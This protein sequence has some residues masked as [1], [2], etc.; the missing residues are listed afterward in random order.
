MAE[1]F[2]RKLERF[3]LLPH[4]PHHESALSDRFHETKAVGC[5]I[6]DLDKKQNQGEIHGACPSFIHFGDFHCRGGGNRASQIARVTG[7][8]FMPPWLPETD[9]V[10]FA[11]V[12]RLTD[13][14]IATIQAW[15]DQGTV[16]GD[17]S[18]LPPAP[19]WTEGW[20]L[21]ETDLVL[22]MHMLPS[23]KPEQIRSSL[24]LHFSSTP[25]RDIPSTLRLGLKI[26][27]I[28]PGDN[29][30]IVRDAYVLP[31][32]VKLLKVY[33]RAHLLC[34]E[35]KG[36]AELPDGSLRRLL[37][38]REWD[39]DWQGEYRYAAPITLL[40]GTTLHMEYTYD[41]SADN[42]RNPNNPP[43]R[44]VYSESTNGEM[45]DLGFQVIPVNAHER[46]VLESHAGIREINL[47]MDA[48]DRAPGSSRAHR[49]LGMILAQRG[50]FKTAEKH[51]RRSLEADST[52]SSDGQAAA[53]FAIGS[54]VLQG[55]KLE[56]AVGHLKEALALRP[57]H[58]KAQA[59]LRLTLAAT[60][61]T[62]AGLRHFRLALQQG[63]E[64][65]SHLNDMAWSLSTR[66]IVDARRP[67]AVVEF[68]EA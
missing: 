9:E 13:K 6:Q 20:Q 16:E 68:A 42:V 66:S 48:V 8:R 56:E 7:S 57:D 17:P 32:D 2:G 51:F 62:D 39:F 1:T 47:Y 45:G 43:Q 28:Q 63:Y 26:F 52:S 14:Q 58:A 55:G 44:V 21:G 36:W 50:D 19:E 4:H 60:G 59:T 5:D 53:H 27:D 3:V 31:I 65:P 54:I 10:Q 34:R 41:N 33:P 12:R 22:D 25:P 49:N 40:K 30:H 23:G 29:N 61:D 35:M 67:A 11:G 64:V 46:T 38:I 37:H 15:V 18:E 24:G